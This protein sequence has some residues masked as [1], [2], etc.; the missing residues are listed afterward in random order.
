MY[1]YK[2][3]VTHLGVSGHHSHCFSCAAPQTSCL[4]AASDVLIKR[5]ANLHKLDDWF[6]R[7][8]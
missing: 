8:H 5:Y 6:N 2:D 3:A 7:V 4:Q 1:S